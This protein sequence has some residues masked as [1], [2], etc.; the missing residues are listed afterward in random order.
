MQVFLCRALLSR[1]FNM[2]SGRER[3]RLSM[4]ESAQ[5]LQLRP[6]RKFIG[7]CRG[8]A[9]PSSRLTNVVGLRLAD[10]AG[11]S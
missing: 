2:A 3:W 9:R 1:I 7:L 5:D 6:V 4:L 11:A 10:N 8:T